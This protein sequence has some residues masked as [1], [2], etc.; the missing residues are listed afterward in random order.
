MS[1][2]LRGLTFGAGFVLAI[3]AAQSAT[4]VVINKDAAGVGFNETTG[5]SP[6]GGN[7]GTTI[8]QQRLIAFQRAADIWAS[9]L[10]SSVPIRIA[11]NFGPLDCQ[12]NFGTLGQ[13]G[14][15]TFLSNTPNIPLANTW[16]PIALVNAYAGSDQRPA[17]D[18][19]EASFNSEIGKPGCIQGL[20]WY[21]GLDGNPPQN[22][23]DFIT[24]L[25]H[26]LGH[27]L[28]FLTLVDLATGVKPSGLDDPFGLKLEFHGTGA[29]SSL[30][31]G[32]RVTASTSV[33]NLHWVGANVVAVSVASLTSGRDSTHVRMYAPN[34]QE[35]GS[36]VSHWDKTATPNQLME[37]SITQSIHMPLLE[38]PAF[39]DIGW[40]I[41][42]NTRDFNGTG[43]SDILW[44]DTSGNNAIWL[45]NGASV[46]SSLPLGNVPAATWAIVGQRDFNNDGRA[47]I[48]WRDTSGNVAIWF[49][50][51][52]SVLSTAGVGSA[53]G[54]NVVGTGDLNGDGWADIVWRDGSGNTAIWLLK[55]GTVIGSAG[56]GLV[57]SSWIV[58]GV[59]DYNGD[60][61]ADLL[62]RDTASGNVAIWFMNGTS[63]VSTA[64]VANL[65]T[66][67]SIVAVGDFNGNGFSDIV[68]RNSSG[69]AAI[70]FMNG[71]SVVSSISL[72]TL[73]AW[74]IVGAGDF[75]GN[76]AS[77]L[78]WRDGSGVTAMWF[79]N[80]GAVSSSATVASVPP[81]WVVQS[82]GAN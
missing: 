60:G 71:A 1:G 43:M 17:L 9:R 67:W 15:T 32:Q 75:D 16:Y 7:P 23:S 10:S 80:N 40:K 31:N 5:A 55:S 78:L 77:D 57:P 46:A 25:L 66:S 38:I 41:P 18:D 59:A 22:S 68:W 48:L 44:R 50:N 12:Q 37:P 3:S 58:A 11:A 45:M 63:V 61:K 6:V 35:D 27:G 26:E 52:G 62:W 39:R 79:F 24:V 13:A 74:N 34:P 53:P 4:V 19:I 49:M 20:S 65:A 28:G 42:I 56:L 47:D 2:T 54:W 30:T 33:T 14:P 36:S 73:A 82:Q 51:G 64:T 8:G 69:S 81:S 72:G 70:W 29:Y 76:G 21:L